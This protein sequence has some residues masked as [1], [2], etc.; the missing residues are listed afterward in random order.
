MASYLPSFSLS[1]LSPIN[2]FP[3]YHGP[4][5]VGTVDVEVPVADLPSPSEAPEGAVET[6]AFR[7][8]YPCAKPSK[9]ET[10]RPVRWIPTPQKATIGAF[11]QFL[12]AGPKMSSL[13]SYMPQ[14]LFWIKIPAYR[15]AK[16]LDAETS[17]HRWPVTVFSHGLAG[18]RN[19]YSYVCGDLASQG[20]VVIALDHRDGSSPIQHVRATANSEARSIPPVK[21]THEPCQEAYEGRDKQLRIRLWEVS[22]AYEALMKIDAGQLVENLDF[23]TS[24]S[25]KERSDV[26]GQFAGMLDI[27]R[28]GKVSWAGHSFGAATTVQLLKSIYYYQDRP[29]DAT[30]PLIAPKSDAAIIQQIMPESPALL[31]DM[32]CL[33]LRSPDQQWLFERPLPT[34]SHGGPKG[35]NVLSVLS[36]SFLN[37]KDN[38]DTTKHVIAAPK[39][40]RRPSVAPRLSREKGKLLPSWARLRDQSP[41]SSMRDSGYSS[42]RS[43]SPLPTLSRKKSGTLSASSSSQASSQQKTSANT[44]AQSPATRSK[45]PH[46]FY[47]LRS[48]HFNQSDFGILFPWLAKRFTKAEEPERILDLNVRAMAQ[49]IRESGIEIGG[50]DDREIL[51]VEAG[52]R[53]WVHVP[54]ADVAE[55]ELDTAE[56]GRKLSVGSGKVRSQAPRDE[57]VEG[58][59]GIET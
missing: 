44:S 1:S 34:Y 36:E 42:E 30:K 58:V 26:L 18:S 47:P 27:H 57:T 55:G 43:R 37:W 15:N 31:L 2:H 11:A 24:W 59:A 19:A 56:V 13:I 6:V 48:Q 10:A 16:L 4:Y 12:G 29:A 50:E 5:D 32:W 41:A 3:S 54:V 8:F 40:S 23:N 39:T 22:M 14:Q 49:V 52:V 35:D 33:P 38:C 46:M 28:P 45:G 53:R 21:I 9:G 51:D 20:M 17:N 25:K 7:I